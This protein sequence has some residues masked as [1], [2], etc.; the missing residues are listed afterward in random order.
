MSASDPELENLQT[1]ASGHFYLL[2]T[3]L[4]N[5][6][7]GA[8]FD[9]IIQKSG[10]SEEARQIRRKRTVNGLDF[11]AS[12]LCFFSEDAPSFLPESDLREKSFGF[13]LLIELTTGGT[14]HLGIFKKGTSRV[15][16]AVESWI[17]PPPRRA[18]VRAFG[19]GGT[20]QK[21]ALKRMTA[22]KHELL[23]SSYEA[24]NLK[25]ALPT[26]GVTRSV[27]RSL[28]IRH[29]TL[30]T[31][32]ISPG[33]FR[34][35]K[36]GGRCG[37]DDLAELVILVAKEIKKSKP[38]EFLDVL[39]Q[40]IDFS[41]KPTTLRPTGV[42]VELGVLLDSPGVEVWRTN[43]NGTERKVGTEF[44]L[45]TIGGALDTKRNGNEWELINE[46][47]HIVGSLKETASG[48][49]LGKLIHP[50]LEVRH[51]HENPIERRRFCTWITR[52]GAFRVV[53]SI[54]EYF[55]SAGQLY[56]RTGFDSDIALV[57]R[58]ISRSLPLAPASSEKGKPKPADT[59][60]PAN[61]IFRIVED[62]ILNNSDY[63]WCS[64]LG[65]EWADYICLQGSKIIFAHCKHGKKATLGAAEYQEVVGQAVKNLGNVKSTPEGFS[66]EI[67]A[68]KNNAMWGNTGIRRLRTLNK[69]WDDFE[70]AIKD[71]IGDPNFSR[72]VHLIITML[73]VTEFEAEAKKAKKRAWFTQLVWLLS[74]FI[75]SCRELGADAKIICLD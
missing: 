18:F 12:F 20:Y 9:D 25:T 3:L 6:N 66:N 38:N 74:A 10:A 65:V 16:E 58:A 34:L 4:T 59:Q 73:S 28:R 37:V 57:R 55:Y 68:A 75:N 22:S 67:K 31:I 36:S 46:G 50:S 47:G 54:P 15:D 11:W 52:K 51:I 24:E 69:T 27:P 29:D 63:L 39:P 2:D 40:E 23:A 44:L 71:R 61:S 49:T 53:F 48:Y 56:R 1:P 8:A 72:E 42:L 32:S 45:R 30:G 26:L 21:L 41:A 33:T 60:F 70:T 35:Q 62:S 19:D 14:R 64:D 13:V 43:A 7:V 5:H 17:K